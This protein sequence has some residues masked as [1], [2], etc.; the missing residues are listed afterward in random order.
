MTGD[1]I[2]YSFSAKTTG[3]SMELCKVTSIKKDPWAGFKRKHTEQLATEN[4]KVKKQEVSNNTQPKKDQP[5]PHICLKCGTELVRGRESY[6]IR[7]WQQ[8]HKNEDPQNSLANIVPK[9]HE[10]ARK[11]LATIKGRETH[12]THLLR[13]HEKTV[14][15]DKEDGKLNDS[16]DQNSATS[17]KSIK[18]V[19][20]TGNKQDS[21]DGACCG[22]TQKGKG[23]TKELTVQSTLNDFIIKEQ[24]AETTQLNNIQGDVNRI[25]LML[26]DLTVESKVKSKVGDST[27][28]SNV[29][30]GSLKEFSNLLEISHPD[31]VIDILDDGCR[32]TCIPCKH[33]FLSQSNKG[34]YDTNEILCFFNEAISLVVNNL[35]VLKHWYRYTDSVL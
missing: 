12:P 18:P 23:S 4:V 6:K 33:Y 1:A 29:N 14:V 35:F 15:V 11:L 25:L 21:V 5:N 30:A 3:S 16:S 22:N 19:T 7:H 17:M 10:S 13:K 2:N 34:R 8:K 24:E 9:N 26:E 32:V 20:T 27:D 28:R 31:I